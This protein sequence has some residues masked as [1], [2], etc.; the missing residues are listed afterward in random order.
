[1]LQIPSHDPRNAMWITGSLDNQRLTVL[2]AV[3]LV[4][5]NKKC[6][7]LGYISNN[8]LCA[9]LFYFTISVCQC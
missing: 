6:S 2:L 9:K 1:M 4:V 8:R 7:S 5:I 3:R